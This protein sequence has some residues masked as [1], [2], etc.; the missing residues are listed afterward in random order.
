MTV[1]EVAAASGCALGEGALWDHRTGT[2]YWVD[3]H[4]PAVWRLN[5]S[6]HAER[7]AVGER[8]G[9]VALTDATDVLLAGF[10]SGLG[11]LT[12][13]TGEVMHLIAPEPERPGNRINDGTVAPDGVVYF[14]T[15]DDSERDATGGFW[16]YDAGRLERFGPAVVVSNGPAVGPDG[17]TL[18][19]VDSV[20]RRIFVRP[21]GDTTND[22]L[23]FAQFPEAWGYPDGLAADEQ[24]FVWVCHW[25]GARITRFDPRGAPER[26][27]DLPVMNITNCAFGGDDFGTLYVT[28]ARAPH[29]AEPYAGHV[30]KLKPGVR[31]F[32]T[33]IARVGR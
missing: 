33:G 9:F 32:A 20:G 27:L 3:I 19:Y 12:W 26:T 7:R 31:G 11:L 6:G 18:Y 4:A 21:S 30:F 10:K 5:P 25:G 2:F 17:R 24:G 8:V 14:G 1:T 13:T 22:D 15:M 23:L 16:R 28:S 29:T